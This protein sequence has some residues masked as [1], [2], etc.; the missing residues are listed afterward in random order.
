MVLADDGPVEISESGVA[1]GVRL[2]APVALG[3]IGWAGFWQSEG[4]AVVPSIFIVLAVVATG[5]ALFDLP[6]A[7]LFDTEGVHRRCLLRTHMIEWD[8]VG[9]LERVPRAPFQPR[10]VFGMIL[11]GTGEPSVT[12]PKGLVLRVGRKRRYLL[13]NRAERPDQWDLLSS[14]IKIWAPHVSIPRRPPV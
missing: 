10:R 12:A 14:R 4:F 3:V 2:S 6:R 11:H 5:I 8:R 9:A 1:L 13:L 7:I